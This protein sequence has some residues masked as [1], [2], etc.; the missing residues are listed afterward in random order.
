MSQDLE[1]AQPKSEAVVIFEN[2]NAGLKAFEEKKKDLIK[3]Q[4]DASGLTIDSIDD[5]IAI[6]Q[7]ST[8]RKKL[9][10]ERVEIEKQGKSMRDPLTKLNKSI[11]AKQDELIDIIGPT[12]KD[13]QSKEDWVKGEQD[14]IDQA[15]ARRKQELIQARID[16]LRAYGFEIDLTFITALGDEDFD[17][18]LDNARIEYE[19]GEAIKAEEA[20]LEQERQ[21]QILKD[22]EEL[23]ALKAKQAEADRIIKERQDELDRQAKALRDQQEE[24]ERKERERA[25]AEADAEKKRRVSQLT[26]LGMSHTWG[27]KQFEGHGEFVNESSIIEY[28]SDKWDEMILEISPRIDAFKKTVADRVEENRLRDIEDAKQKAIADEQERQRVAAEKKKEDDRLA[29]AKKQQEL[30][31]AGDKAVWADFISKLK[32]LPVPS[33]NSSQYRRMAGATRKMLIDIYDLKP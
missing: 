5:K 33:M 13:L 26:A 4:Q 29:E 15:E 25:K 11:S 17:K 32:A 23:K 7:V 14:K 16:R 21:A 18:V 20:R 24:A 28:S 12:E 19:K 22:Q 10:S 8:W 31:A 9:K 1:V 30:E 27:H 2:I 3:L 6:N